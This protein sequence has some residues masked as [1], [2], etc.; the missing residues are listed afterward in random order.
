MRWKV[1]G[2]VVFAIIIAVFTTFNSRLVTV[3]FVFAQARWSLILVILLSVFLGM[4]V[5]ALLWSLRAWQLR[6][7]LGQ[8]KRGRK[9]HEQRIAEL[10]HIV[11]HAELPDTGGSGSS[12]E[13]PV[14]EPNT[15]TEQPV[16]PD[17]TH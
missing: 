3:N 6:R 17:N 16:T 11:S 2:L 10:E 14:D 7:Q 4:A 8:F 15:M 1:I 13:M 12:V 5:M 9:V